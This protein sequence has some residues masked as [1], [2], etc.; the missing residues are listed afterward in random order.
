MKSFLTTILVSASLFTFGQTT[1]KSI[2]DIPKKW[3]LVERDSLGYLIYDP[4]NGGTPIITIDNGYVTI[5]WQLDGPSKLVINKFTRLTGNK[6]FYINASDEG[7][8]MEFSAVLKNDKEKLAL[9][10]F[11]DFKWVMTPYENKVEFRQV[12][13]P[14]PTEMKPE[15]QFLP[16]EF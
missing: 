11:G 8:N 10:T 15:K 3:I 4:C 12:N 1:W 13:N 14:C 9:W 7:G 5:Y 16:V 2:D 6:S